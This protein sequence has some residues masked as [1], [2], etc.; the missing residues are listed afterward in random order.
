MSSQVRHVF[1]GRALRTLRLGAGAA[2]LASSLLLAPGG[3]LAKDHCPGLAGAGCTLTAPVL[4][5]VTPAAADPLPHDL[6]LRVSPVQAVIA[7]PRSGGITVAQAGSAALAPVKSTNVIDPTVAAVPGWPDGNV[8]VDEGTVVKTGDN[9]PGIGTVTNGT[10]TIKAGS[11]T[12]DG[13]VSA[14]I[15]AEGSGQISIDV[16]TVETSG[17]RSD[18]IFATTN[19]GGSTGGI[20]IKAGSIDT[21][22]D[23]SNG[24]TA[25]AYRGDVTIDVGQVKTTGYGAGGIYANAG[26][27][28][29]TVTAGTVNTSGESARG[30][31]AYSNGT[32]KVVVDSVSTVGGGA[33]QDANAGAIIAMGTSVE[34]HAGTVS[35]QGDYSDGIYASS[36]FTYDNGQASHDIAITA[37]SVSTAGDRAAGIVAINV[38]GD[39]HID[40]GT[41]KTTGDYATGVYALSVYGNTSIK[42]GDV[43]TT[44]YASQGVYG[45]AIFG[46]DVN[47]DVGK[48]TTAGDHAPAVYGLAYYGNVTIKAGEVATSGYHSEGVVG[49]GAFGGKVSIQTGNVSTTGDFSAGVVGVSGSF[50]APSAGGGV[51]IKLDGDVSTAGLGS[52]GVF[53]Y[54]IEGDIAITGKGSI[55]TAGDYAR[56]IF[57]QAYKGDVDIDVGNI[58]TGG[59]SSDGI[60]VRA[61]DSNLTI[62]AGDLVTHGGY[63]NGVE[64]HMRGDADITVGNVTTNGLFASGLNIGASA[65]DVH[66][67]GDLTTNGM[68]SAGAFLQAYDGVANLTVDGKTLTNGGGSTGLMVRGAQG[69]VVTAGEVITYG[70]NASGII[71]VS[72]YGDVTVNA[73]GVTTKGF[74]GDGIRARTFSETGGITINNTGAIKVSGAYSAGIHVISQGGPIKI[75]NPGKISVYG[76]YGMGIYARV[77]NG[78]GAIDISAGDIV[79]EGYRSAGVIAL[80]L[81][82]VNIDVGAISGTKSDGALGLVAISNG[83]GNVNVTA[84]SV[85]VLGTAIQIGTDGNVNLDVGDVKSGGSHS[86][87]IQ[88]DSK[89]DVT[90]KAGK[91]DSFGLY[92]ATAIAI[93]TEGAV[94][95][96][97]ADVV[98]QADGSNAIDVHAGSA[99]IRVTG[100]VVTLLDG[101]TGI[102]ARSDAG[103]TLVQ[104]AGTV[105]T[106]GVG[107]K[108]IY[109][110]GNGNVALSANEVVTLRGSSTAITGFSTAG[111]V[112][113]GVNSVATSGAD[114]TG[115]YGAVRDAY[116]T[117]F[118]G[119]VTITAG[120]VAT[121]GADSVGVVGIN[122]THGGNVDITVSDV[123]TRR[124]KAMG[125]YA[126][127]SY[128]SGKVVAGN[129]STRGP[130]AHGVFVN[131]N[132]IA[133]VTVNSVETLG[134]VSTGIS[135]W[136][137]VGSK[138]KAGK[139]ETSGPGSTGIHGLT[140]I[141]S[142]Y[143]T[144]RGDVEIT[145]GEVITHGD[146]SIGI[147]AQSKYGSSKV[148][149]GSITTTGAISSGVFTYT[150]GLLGSHL[151]ADSRIYVNAVLT[152][153]EGSDGIYV[154]GQYSAVQI[155][156]GKI[157]TEGD[158]SAGIRTFTHDTSQLIEVHDVA[159][160]GYDSWGVLAHAAN[161]DVSIKA[162]GMVTTSGD[163]AEAIRANA[164]DGHVSLEVANVVTTGNKAEGVYAF[165]VG[166]T[167]SAEITA[168]SIKTSGDES[169]GIRAYN[170]NGGVI[171]YKDNLVDASKSNT[172][173]SSV[174]ASA[175]DLAISIEAGS[176]DVSGLGAKGI[177]VQGQGSVSTTVGNVKSAQDEAIHLLAR[178][179]NALTVRGAVSG[180]IGDELSNIAAVFMT[181]SDVNFTAAS[182]AKISGMVGVSAMATGAAPEAEDPGIGLPEEPGIGIGVLDAT[183]VTV[184]GTVRIENAGTI[185]GTRAAISTI[186]SNS[187]IVNRGVIDG[188][189]VTSEGDD[190]ITN[191]GT[192]IFGGSRAAT[193]FGG[194]N[195]LLINSGIVR[196]A[197][198]KEGKPSVAVLNDLSRFENSGTLSLQNGVAGDTLTLPGDYVASGKAKLGIDLGGQGKVSDRLVV[199]GAAT[200][201]TSISLTSTDGYGATLLNGPLRIVTVGAGSA[202]NAF[203]L[204]S[205][206]I[207]FVRYGLTYDAASRSY[208]V[209]STAGAPVYRFARLN[210]GAQSV[211]LK[212]AEAFTTHMRT[213]RDLGDPGRRI[214]GQMSGGVANR[215]E[216]RAVAGGNGF[217]AT[218]YDLDYRQDFYGGELGFDAVQGDGVTAGVMGGYTSSTQRFKANGDKGRTDALN[219][220][221]YG[222]VT[223]GLLFANLL[224][225]YDHFSTR[226]SS[227]QMDWDDTIDG[228]SIGAQGEVGARLGSAKFFV[229]PA[230]SL[231]WQSTS[232]GDIEPLDQTI[233][234]DK[235]SGLRGRIGAR[236]GG[237]AKL[238][239]TE[240]TFYGA[241]DFVHEF[242]GDDGA[243]LVSGGQSVWVPGARMADYGQATLGLDIKGSGPVSGFIQGSGT[244]GSSYSGVDGR[245]GIRFTF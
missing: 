71:A 11:I 133:D 51:D 186:M 181:G 12:T 237:V 193:G 138:V 35:T 162:T 7:A 221:A 68:L 182:G 230:A 129:V 226:V 147:L 73:N 79:T 199:E 155:A 194:G 187:I 108:G 9:T 94:R 185:T 112:T 109:A 195:N 90:V 10:T 158:H 49:I 183:P 229:E 103:D 125:I 172:G 233:A 204:E 39:N 26:E 192:W 164:S 180:G 239:G 30:V 116:G 81:G 37:G 153:G 224:V 21:T 43:S 232:L 200:G 166:I 208:S 141:I 60:Y 209:L 152:K 159:T 128:G 215:D 235:A 119:D 114:S 17:W 55:T 102:N 75:D 130:A 228:H 222:G 27:G 18:G 196:L 23:L 214:W 32:T 148:T 201:S 189:I 20:A 121:R 175:Q 64:V 135:A 163:G 126:Y 167:K 1:H 62:K 80:G 110:G 210:E 218:S 24:I 198:S 173:M 236:L 234:F 216:T 118:K 31:V 41:V 40:V 86:R 132:Q 134:D 213:S 106:D 240:V 29:A 8:V 52:H 205:T 146:E 136:S 13:S 5:R 63:A 122:T 91:I 98:T 174:N 207:G 117:G 46:G 202:A 15:H 107:S 150:R 47:I 241:G 165:L 92:D 22:G 74:Y 6:T 78:A 113:I 137:F 184:K 227:Q 99:D 38:E 69:A 231:A 97:A 156:A 82:D 206:D 96:M 61:L 50:Y 4:A 76:D 95:L 225:K 161:G 70:D 245:A 87:G 212:S 220:G 171:A 89:G 139:V 140:G 244:F 57:A 44:G 131:V 14:G 179:S 217:G 177:F 168:G 67:A 53:A 59:F 123:T 145:A 144:Y 170:L 25:T 111:D 72:E 104:V 101:S 88:I 48:V 151:R 238:L 142:N 154:S 178:G 242:K 42:A 105:F 169:H 176:I 115:V 19:V 203:T 16:G 190:T 143:L 188:A 127:S 211:W 219:V 243:T 28:N 33:V 124:E 84:K 120:T 34:V 157:V 2:A 191:Y 36:N 58:E 223:R 54:A 56:G 149:A 83:G 93:T 65:I 85:E 197:A 66:V 100:D 45:K 160:S 3:A 77:L